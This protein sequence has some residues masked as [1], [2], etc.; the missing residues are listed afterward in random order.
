MKILNTLKDWIKSV[1]NLIPEWTIKQDG[2]DIY[3]R[4]NGKWKLVTLVGIEEG[5]ICHRNTAVIRDCQGRLKF[6]EPENCSCHLGHPPC[7]ACTSTYLYCPE[8]GWE[9][10]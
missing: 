10:A 5:D 1:L 8:C 6:S 7:S 9:D 3:V 2:D 4:R